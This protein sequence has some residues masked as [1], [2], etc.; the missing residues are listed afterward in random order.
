MVIII[1]EL[2]NEMFTRR[3]EET[4][5]WIIDRVIIIRGLINWWVNE[6]QIQMAINHRNH[7]A[8]GILTT[9]NNWWVREK[10]KGREL[11]PEEKSRSVRICLWKINLWVV[12]EG[13]W[14]Q[15]N[16]K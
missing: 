15:S 2:R 11:M 5:K 9:T 10:E 3:D 1:I 4:L 12:L 16:S 6:P 13:N 14:D 7:F 8:L